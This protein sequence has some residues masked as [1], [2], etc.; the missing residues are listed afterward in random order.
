MYLIPQTLLLIFLFL[1]NAS[2]TRMTDEQRRMVL[3]QLRNLGED[4]SDVCHCD[5]N[6]GNLETADI[7]E[8][9]R[10][11]EPLITSNEGIFR[12]LLGSLDELARINRAYTTE[13][14]PYFLAYIMSTLQVFAEIS[15][16]SGESID[17]EDLEI[18]LSILQNHY[19][20]NI[21]QVAMDVLTNIDELSV[22]SGRG[23]QQLTISTKNGRPIELDL[24][25]PELLGDQAG[26][27]NRLKRLRIQNGA[28]IVFATERARLTNCEIRQPD[29]SIRNM[30]TCNTGHAA[31]EML[32]D[33]NDFSFE[34]NAI[35]Q[36]QQS[37]AL[38]HIRSGDYLSSGM[39]PLYM[40]F[41]GIDVTG[42][43]SSF[44]F[45]VDTNIEFQSAVVIPGMDNGERSFYLEGQ[46]TAAL[47]N[48]TIQAA[49]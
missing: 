9:M 34:K 16:S 13:N 39:H 21:P 11:W 43:A 28:R 17:H 7:D 20:I 6:P 18:V 23:I 2:A 49:L 40:Q 26:S 29:G 46:V 45:N 37:A 30:S 44:I 27:S 22:Q 42:R 14:D 12:G 35:T 4:I 1:Q 33:V 36:E 5:V 8:V 47:T 41:S 25:R 32:S 38:G 48:E 3:D 10:I 19:G 24:T 31:E 15:A